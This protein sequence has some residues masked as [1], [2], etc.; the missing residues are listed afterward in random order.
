M[1]ELQDRIRIDGQVIGTQTLKVDSFLNHQIDPA[2]IM[3]M[4]ETLADK[5][6]Q[7]GVTKILTVESSGIAVAMAAGLKLGVPVVFAKKKPAVTQDSETYLADVFS[8]TRKEAVQ[9]SVAAKFLVKDDVIL[10]IDDFLAH[11]E[12][13]N[14]MVS[15]VRQS[16]AKLAGAGIVIEKRFQEGGKK[17]RAAGIRIETLAAIEYME[18]GT[19]RFAQN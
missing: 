19:I 4:G 1:K 18:P 10:I 2:F 9:I 3:R 14:G 8:F 16:G 17:L 12:A 11:G 6:T 5:F 13:L 7:D 15:I